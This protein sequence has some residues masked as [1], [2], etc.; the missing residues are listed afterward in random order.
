MIARMSP[1]PSIWHGLLQLYILHQA[2]KRPTYGGKLKKQ[3]A[4]HG[5]YI[6]PG[7][8]YPLLHN[9]ERSGLLRGWI[10]V[11]K[12]RARKHY[13]ITEPGRARL[14]QLRAELTAAVAELLPPQ[15]N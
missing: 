8:L 14:Q 5:Y 9:L 1:Q 12:G 13:E 3:L 6:S 10:K 4:L 11:Y 7:S 15:E 2:E